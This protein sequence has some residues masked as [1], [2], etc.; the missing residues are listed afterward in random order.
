MNF[1]FQTVAPVLENFVVL[2]KFSW[3]KEIKLVKIFMVKACPLW[4]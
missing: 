4:F 3:V 2:Q 1:F